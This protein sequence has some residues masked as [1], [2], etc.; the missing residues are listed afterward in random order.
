MS[1]P[2]FRIARQEHGDRVRRAA[3]R[4]ATEHREILDRPEIQLRSDPPS[5][6]EAVDLVVAVAASHP[7]LSKLSQTPAGWARPRR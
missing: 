1:G 5:V 7:D 3:R 6:D 2:G 4:M